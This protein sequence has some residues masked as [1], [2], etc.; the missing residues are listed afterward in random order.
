MKLDRTLERDGKFPP[1]PS[2]KLLDWVERIRKGWRPNRRISNMSYNEM[3]EFM[4]LWEI[5][6]LSVIRPLLNSLESERQ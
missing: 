5:E 3:A 2:P 4:G 6:V 1:M